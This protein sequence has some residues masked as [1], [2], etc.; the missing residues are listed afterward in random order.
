LDSLNHEMI[1]VDRHNHVHES[2]SI[3]S[4]VLVELGRINSNRLWIGFRHAQ[5]FAN[6]SSPD[7]PVKRF[8]SHGIGQHRSDQLPRRNQ[9][10][11]RVLANR[12]TVVPKRP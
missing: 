5:V 3:A 6:D 10:E 12:E 4:C 2:P 1:A 7:L 8:S 9:Q 11:Q